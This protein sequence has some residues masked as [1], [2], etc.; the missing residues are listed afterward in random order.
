MTSKPNP[1]A[2]GIGAPE[3]D[4]A[5][6]MIDV[7]V[8]AEMIGCSPRHA[9]RMADGG[10]MPRPI[11]LGGLIRWRRSDILE[12]IQAGCPRVSVPGKSRNH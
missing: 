2:E 6:L 9:R 3:V 12:W 8:V 10:L 4:P 5:V 1:S 7:N 11:R